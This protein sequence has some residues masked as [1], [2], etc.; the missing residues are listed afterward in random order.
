MDTPSSNKDLLDRISELEAQLE[1]CSISQAEAEERL[2]KLLSTIPDPVTIIKAD[3]GICIDVNDEFLRVSGWSREE[4]V[5][6]TAETSGIWVNPEDRDIFIG[7][8]RKHGSVHSLEADF[9][10]KD[11]TTYTGLF[12]AAFFTIG[13]APH[14]LS[15]TRDISR[16]KKAEEENLNL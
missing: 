12:S 11:R 3:T 14:I 9:Y 5:G 7:A 15:I 6:Q 10:R 4:I 13:G 8:I 2:Q 1:A 16:R